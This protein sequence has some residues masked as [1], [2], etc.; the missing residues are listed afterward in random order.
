MNPMP[1]RPNPAPSVLEARGR[2][3]RRRSIVAAVLA[4]DAGVLA[5]LLLAMGGLD[6]ALLVIATFF[7]WLIALTLVWY[8][9]G[10]AVPDQRS[11]MAVA[12]LLGAWVVVGGLLLDWVVAIVVLEGALGPLDYVLQRY[13]IVIPVLALLLGPGM[14]AFRSR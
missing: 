11:R 14:A 3:R 4:A 7:G 10:V 5:W 13:G 8:G 12:A 6:P 9:R 2:A 1:S